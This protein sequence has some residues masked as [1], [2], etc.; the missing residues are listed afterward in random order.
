MPDLRCR[1][2]CQ[3]ICHGGDHSKKCFSLPVC[4]FVEVDFGGMIFG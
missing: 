1:H 4:W 3:N 2:I